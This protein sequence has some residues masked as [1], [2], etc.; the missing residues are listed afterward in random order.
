MTAPT[1]VK[2]LGLTKTIIAN[3]ISSYKSK[4]SDIQSECKKLVDIVSKDLDGKIPL[5]PIAGVQMQIA[6]LQSEMATE[7]STLEAA[8]N[9]ANAN[10]GR[11]RARIRIELEKQDKAGAKKPPISDL[12]TDAYNSMIDTDELDMLNTLYTVLNTMYKTLDMIKDTL[13]SIS[14]SAASFRKYSTQ[15]NTGTSTDDTNKS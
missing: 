7:L 15:L 10:E 2:F 1:K 6:L 11:E 8:V 14:I 9:L 5:G 3:T 12:V 4:I 13:R